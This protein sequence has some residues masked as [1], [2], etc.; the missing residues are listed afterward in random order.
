M[1]VERVLGEFALRHAYMHT[2]NK[3]L[4]GARSAMERAIS[5]G[6]MTKA[7]IALGE[8]Q[9]FEVAIKQLTMYEK[10]EKAIL[11]LNTKLG[12]EGKSNG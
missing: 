9:A 4:E 3:L 8:K 11:D 10:E 7:S 6:N 1:W 5:D 2:F 12:K